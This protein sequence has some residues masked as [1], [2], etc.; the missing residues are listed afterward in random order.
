MA[1]SVR[2]RSLTPRDRPEAL[3]RLDRA[4]RL[5]LFLIDL[6]LRMGEAVQGR[7]RSDLLGAWRGDEL[8]GVASVQPS[9]VLDASAEPAALAA[10]FP[11]LSTVASGLVKSNADVV[12]PLHR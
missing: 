6:A 7:G 4:A 9:L 8:V 1:R 3:A 2:V 11:Y 12:A 5:N 10:F